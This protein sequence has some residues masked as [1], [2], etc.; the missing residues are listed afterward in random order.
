M[1]VTDAE[2]VGEKWLGELSSALR[3]LHRGPCSSFL[4][5]ICSSFVRLITVLPTCPQEEGMTLLV[6]TNI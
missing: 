1:P 2:V 4:L 5:K 3:G 6:R